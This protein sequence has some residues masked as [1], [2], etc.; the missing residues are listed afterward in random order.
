MSRGRANVDLSAHAKSLVIDHP[1]AQLDMIALVRDDSPKD[2][3]QHQYAA[4]HLD[5]E[6]KG[7]SDQLNMAVFAGH[8]K[9]VAVRHEVPCEERCGTAEATCCRARRGKH[10]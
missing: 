10:E 6:A 9:L 1:A 8:G 5:S 2:V 7:P 4:I 3:A